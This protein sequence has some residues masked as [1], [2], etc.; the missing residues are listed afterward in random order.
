MTKREHWFSLVAEQ[1]QSSDTNIAR[2][3]NLSADRTYYSSTYGDYVQPSYKEP[4]GGVDQSNILLE[5]RTLGKKYYELTDHLGNV[6]AT[7]MDRRTGGGSS[8]VGTLYS[9]WKADIATATDYYPFGMMMP[10]RY[11]MMNGD[12]TVYRFGFNGQEKDN[13]I[14][15]PGNHNTALFWEY[16]TRT[17]RRW[18]LD[19]KPHIGISDYSVLGNNPIFNVDPNGDYFFGLIGSTS[20]QRKATKSFAKQTGGEVKNITSR[21]DIHVSYSG[22]TSSVENGEVTVRA[23]GNVYF[24]A[25]GDRRER[26]YNHN[27]LDPL[28]DYDPNISLTARATAG[29]SIYGNV[30]DIGF[31]ARYKEF[32]VAGV[33]DNQSELMSRSRNGDKGNFRT[34]WNVMGMGKEKLE[35]TTANGIKR[36]LSTTTLSNVPF[37]I[38]NYS[39]REDYDPQTGKR[40]RYHGIGVGGGIGLGLG[41]EAEAFFKL[42][43]FDNK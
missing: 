34:G 43:G 30:N 39:I 26:S 14:A 10:G 3:N 21:T 17:A 25:D 37:G 9:H 1:Q 31:A 4:W 23:R 8:G 32:T 18:N 12:T 6:L 28:D 29:A 42:G 24:D 33:K 36:E 22:S 19:P 2:L 38:F 40:Q 41:V 13:E 11:K 35:R 16:D 5:E 20:A 15:G 27:T 7:V